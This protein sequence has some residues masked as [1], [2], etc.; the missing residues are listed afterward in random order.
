MT[1]R[2]ISITLDE[3]MIERLDA[4]AALEGTTRTAIIERALRNDLP[5]QESFHKDLENP[6]M[7]ALHAQITR[8][9][10]VMRTLATM[11][12]Q[13][14][15]EEQIERILEKAPVDRERAKQRAAER[16]KSG[17]PKPAVGEG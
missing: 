6:L 10:T 15:T 14:L 11:V 16:R 12:R 3:P 13:E 5:E 1:K 8:S 2:P 9:P 17:T 7:R 4:L